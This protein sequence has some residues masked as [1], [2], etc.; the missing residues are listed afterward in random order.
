MI[1][2]T[3][4]SLKSDMMSQNC[5]FVT[6][7]S[8]VCTVIMLTH[9]LIIDW[10][11]IAFCEV[12]DVFSVNEQMRNLCSFI[13]RV[14]NITLCLSYSKKFTVIENAMSLWSF[15][16]MNSAQMTVK[17]EECK[18]VEVLFAKNY[19]ALQENSKIW[20]SV[21]ITCREVSWVLTE[22]CE[23]MRVLRFTD[24]KRHNEKTVMK[25]VREWGF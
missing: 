2:V 13:W 4:Q 17:L 22:F 12:T 9:C 23:R 10:L 15:D 5:S 1:I 20:R 7:N 14:Y 11:M 8:V 6:L 18:T 3:E 24:C 25:K 16:F 21:M 19:I